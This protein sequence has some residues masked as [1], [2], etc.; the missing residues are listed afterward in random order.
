MLPSELLT[1]AL[2]SLASQIALGER[3][4]SVDPRELL[5]RIVGHVDGMEGSVGMDEGKKYSADYLDNY[6][7]DFPPHRR[8]V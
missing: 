6:V 8:I 4:P 7:R 2:R 5:Q 1:S 3:P